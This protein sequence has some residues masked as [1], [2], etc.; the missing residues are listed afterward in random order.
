MKPHD[1]KTLEN[2][3]NN[4]ESTIKRRLLVYSGTMA[5]MLLYAVSSLL[6]NLFLDFNICPINFIFGIPCPGC[7]MSRALFYAL[8]LNFEKAFAMHPLFALV[9][10]ALIAYSYLYIFKN[11]KFL[12]NKIS[13]CILGTVLIITYIVRMILFFPGTT[14]MKFNEK[15]LI[16][17]ILRIFNN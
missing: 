15:S 9:P 6:L 16:G 11:K 10:L 14:P 17:L 12:S 3:K 8:T 4:S 5:P 2:L 1:D 7:G 13:L